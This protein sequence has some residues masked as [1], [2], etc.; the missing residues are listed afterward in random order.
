MCHH[1]Q[2]EFVCFA[3]FQFAFNLYAACFYFVILLSSARV[4]E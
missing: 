1:R 4:C 2:Q 3:V